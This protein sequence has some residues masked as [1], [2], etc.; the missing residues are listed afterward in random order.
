MSVHDFER[1]ENIS[2]ADFPD[3]YAGIMLP[4]IVFV[5]Q[6]KTNTDIVFSSYTSSEFYPLV[7]RT[8]ENYAVASSIISATVLGN[9]SEFNGVIYIVLRLHL[10][11]S[12]SELCNIP[13]QNI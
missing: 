5:N 11:V 3:N 12:H 6:T 2:A 9:D 8:L 7:N 10:E 13:Y 4:P 1:E